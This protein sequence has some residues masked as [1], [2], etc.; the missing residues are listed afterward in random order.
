MRK[1]W[2]CPDNCPN[3]KSCCQNPDTCEIYEYATRMKRSMD[4][5]RGHEVRPFKNNFRNRSV[6]TARGRAR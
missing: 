2:E 4:V 3:R 5:K 1:E 6:I